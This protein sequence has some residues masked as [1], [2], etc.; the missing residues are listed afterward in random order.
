MV[1]TNNLQATAGMTGL[2]PLSFICLDYHLPPL[3]CTERGKQTVLDVDPSNP[4]RIIYAHGKAIYLVDFGDATK[5]HAYTEHSHACTVAKFSPSGFYVAS[6]D[7]SGCV[8]VWDATQREH[9]L[10]GEYRVLGGPVR[11]LAWDAESRHIIAVGEGREKYSL[12][13]EIPHTHP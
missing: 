9:V 6:G 12:C 13:M 11:D 10:K 7:V 3:P 1:P 2:C 8:R 4:T 5:T